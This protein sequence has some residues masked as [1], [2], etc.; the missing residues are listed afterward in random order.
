[1]TRAGS[2]RPK[3]NRPLQLPVFLGAEFLFQIIAK[4]AEKAAVIFTINLPFSEW[5]QV[6][7]N[8]WL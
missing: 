3:V 7:P 2:F 6:I 4:R 8:A 1:M 5:T